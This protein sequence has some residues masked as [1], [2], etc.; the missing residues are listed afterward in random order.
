MFVCRF[1]AQSHNFIA[2]LDTVEWWCENDLCSLSWQAQQQQEG[3][4]SASAL[5]DSQ[6]PSQS[7]V[8]LGCFCGV[9]FETFHTEH[10]FLCTLLNLP[11]NWT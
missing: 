1:L 9:P 2:S 5:P 4:P 11:F 7:E 3:E 6:D 10:I 8:G